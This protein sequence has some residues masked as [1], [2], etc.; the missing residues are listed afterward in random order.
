MS[1]YRFFAIILLL[2][3]SYSYSADVMIAPLF[4]QEMNNKG[5]PVRL[6]FRFSVVED[7][8]ELLIY[9]DRPIGDIKTFL[10]GSPKRLV[11][12]VENADLPEGNIK[13]AVDREELE[14]IRAARHEGKVR[15]VFD[16]PDDRNI[17]HRS[18]RTPEGVKVIVELAGK[19]AD[20]APALVKEETSQEP[21]QPL[22]SEDVFQ[23]E[24]VSQVG[25]LTSQQETSAAINRKYAGKKMSIKLYKAD[26]RDFFSRVSKAGGIV[27]EVAPD[28][29][30]QVTLRLTDM[31]WDQ[32][33]DTVVHL[34]NLKLEK[35]K[36]GY[37]VSPGSP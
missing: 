27:I 15:F 6:E 25:S 24:D 16:L 8:S 11:L 4:A 26:I 33:L 31:P 28:L 35:R 29:Q 12:D 22:G 21:P 34:Y 32:A 30:A 13:M 18:E 3:L 36:N 17:H 10:L 1:P 23:S 14:A 5:S 19:Q 9:A 20:T 37:Y 7:H 2:S